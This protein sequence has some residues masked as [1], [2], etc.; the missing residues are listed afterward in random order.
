MQVYPLTLDAYQNDRKR[1]IRSSFIDTLPLLSIHD[2]SLLGICGN[3]IVNV[4]NNI[5][6]GDRMLER[7]MEKTRENQEGRE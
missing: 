1:L 6:W 4:N 3:D 7:S 2:P 5:Y